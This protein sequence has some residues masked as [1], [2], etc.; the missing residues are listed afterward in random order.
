MI[1]NN[2]EDNNDEDDDNNDDNSNENGDND[3]DNNKNN[4]SN[5]NNNA[6][7]QVL[8]LQRAHG[9]SIN[10][11]SVDIINKTNRL[12]V[13]HTRQYNNKINKLYVNNPKTMNENKTHCINNNNGKVMG[14]VKKKRHYTSKQCDI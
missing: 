5:N 11:N 7:I 13:L 3:D 10:N 4:A 1:N 14:K 8:F 2:N 9:S 6:Y 12:K